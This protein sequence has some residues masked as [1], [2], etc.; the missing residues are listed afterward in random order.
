[1]K[2]LKIT[3][4]ANAF[5]VDNRIEHLDNV[6]D[7]EIIESELHKSCDLIG[8]TYKFKERELYTTERLC[9]VDTIETITGI[10]IFENGGFTKEIY[11]VAH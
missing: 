6:T 7:I 8:F 4:K 3:F 10:T 9:I 1:M 5:T 11:K 2:N